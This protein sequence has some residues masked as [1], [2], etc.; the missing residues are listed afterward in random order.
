MQGTVRALRWSVVVLWVAL[1]GILVHAQM[2]S[3]QSAE[4][5]VG[6]AD[7][8]GDTNAQ[9]AEESWMGV[10]MRDQKIG[11]SHHRVAPTADGYRIEELSV[12]RATILATAQTVRFS[13]QGNLGRDFALRDFE[14]SLQS[15]VG[16]FELNGHVNGTAVTLDMKVGDE[17]R[18]EN[19]PLEEPIYLP[20]G[21]RRRLWAGGMAAGREV[22]LRVFDPAA[23]KSQP[24]V[25][26]VEGRAQL[27]GEKRDAW[28]VHESF[29]GI[30]T[31]VWL[32]D[33]GNSLREEGPMGMVT[34]RE[35]ADYAM[36]EGWKDGPQIDLAT[37][38]AIRINH[39]IDHPRALGALVLRLGGLNGMVPPSDA[40]QTFHDGVIRIARESPSRASFT[41]PYTGSEW[42]DELRATPFLQSDHPKLHEKAR[43]ILD[44]ETDARHAAQL[45]R[46]WVYR[47]LEKTP[48]ASI[49]NA[50]Q[51]L[52]MGRGDCNEHAVLFAA[53]ARAAGLPARVVAGTVYSETGAFLYHAWNE[54]WLGDGWVSADAAFNQMPVDAT[55][56][57]LIAGGPEQH[58][59]LLQVIGR[60]SIE[61]LTETSAGDYPPH[62][63]VDNEVALDRK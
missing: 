1:V 32:D 35:S 33:D 54:V 12:L 48:V 55:H 46:S 47:N 45:L 37:I 19:L 59:E 39:P 9:A 62:A 29:H 6:A 10:Y 56:L 36:S 18:T 63:S 16:T 22:T 28:K 24:V 13:A 26:R 3:G 57:K 15:G 7:A 52:E 50:L 14:V 42:Q 20:L 60:L 40:R 8:P 51:V 34:V 2:P 21:A 61:V 11:Y 30:D 23:M 17:T 49:P 53:L 27:A 25:M 5:V 41:L 44:G 31:V 43:A 58:V 4:R 38:S